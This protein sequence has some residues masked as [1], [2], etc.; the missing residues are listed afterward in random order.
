M[1]IGLDFGAQRGRW[2]WS[3]WLLLLVDGGGDDNTF[4]SIFVF[5]IQ[6][7]TAAHR[8]RLDQSQT[9]MMKMRIVIIGVISLRAHQ[10]LAR[11]MTF[12]ADAT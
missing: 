2:R 5:G 8:F 9:A 10:L 12:N 6:L 1:A 7:V 3:M 11:R 4:V